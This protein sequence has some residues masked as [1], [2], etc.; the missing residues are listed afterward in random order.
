MSVFSSLL[1]R[2]R[3]RLAFNYV[4]TAPE[5]ELDERLREAREAEDREGMRCPDCGEKHADWSGRGDEYVVDDAHNAGV[6]ARAKCERCGHV[7]EVPRR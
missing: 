3:D 6:I 4:T 7:E 2:L 5:G 1:R